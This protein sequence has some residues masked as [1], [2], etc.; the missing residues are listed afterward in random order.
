M[1]GFSKE[2]LLNFLDFSSRGGAVVT[3][4]TYLKSRRSWARAPSLPLDLTHYYV[5]S[6]H[7]GEGGGG[8]YPICWGMAYKCVPR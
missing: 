2:S 6:T 8:F 1:V 4:L 3:A 7:V 5:E